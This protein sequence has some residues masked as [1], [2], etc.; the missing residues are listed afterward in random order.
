[1]N[2][3]EG[4]DEDVKVEQADPKIRVVLESFNPHLS[5][6]VVT[7]DRGDFIGHDGLFIFVAEGT[8]DLYRVLHL[9]PKERVLSVEFGQQEEPVNDLT[10]PYQDLPFLSIT[11]VRGY[12]VWPHGADPGGAVLKTEMDHGSS[13]W[14]A[15]AD[16]V[17]AVAKTGQEFIIKNRY[18][19]C[20]ARLG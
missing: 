11:D 20:E 14:Y 19:P 12:K 15:N 5:R 2:W 1:M 13:G 17:V 16:K 10:V 9:F 7:M 3:R 6:H 4:M 18:G 8:P